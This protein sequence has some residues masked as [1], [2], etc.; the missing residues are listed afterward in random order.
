MI[1]S[2]LPNYIV[3][4][5]RKVKENNMKVNINNDIYILTIEEEI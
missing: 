4:Y 5:Q 2:L 3:H 1:Q